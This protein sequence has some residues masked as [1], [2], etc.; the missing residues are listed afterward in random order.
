VLNTL[1]FMVVIIAVGNHLADGLRVRQEEIILG[2]LP[3]AQAHAFYERL[4]QRV[5]QVRLLRAITLASAVLLLLAARRHFV[6]PPPAPGAAAPARAQAPTNTG[7]AR[8]LAEAELRRNGTDPA[9]LELIEVR[10]D[11][12]Y[13][14]IFDYRGR[15][16]G[17]R[18]RVY[19]DREGRAG[20]GRVTAD[21]PSG[22]PAVG[23]P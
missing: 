2:K 16:S 11:E 9:A 20:F 21:A 3:T 23:R 4:R 17:E 5:R 19:V 1:V 18:L 7:A 6:A 10:G 14:W 22:G 8:A 15:A 13:P 12:R